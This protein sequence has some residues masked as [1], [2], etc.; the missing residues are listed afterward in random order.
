MISGYPVLTVSGGV[1]AH[2]RIGYTEAL[3]DANAKRGNRN[4]VGN[5]RVLGLFDEF[6]PDGG[7]HRVFQPL[8]FRTWRYLE[9]D[10]ETGDAPLQ[11]DSLKVNFSAFPF[12]QRGQFL[13]SDPKLIKS[14]GSVAHSQA[15]CA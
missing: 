8:W 15:G 14:G 1:A 4:D 13:S 3:Y 7:S 11:L 9:L 2:I 5:R 10:I 12:K 6:I